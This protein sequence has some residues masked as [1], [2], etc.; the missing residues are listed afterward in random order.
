ML[1]VEM[2]YEVNNWLLTQSD[3]KI[4]RKIYRETPVAGNVWKGNAQQELRDSLAQ[5]KKWGSTT[6]AKK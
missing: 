3:K 6:A 2:V 4:F 1:A 5:P